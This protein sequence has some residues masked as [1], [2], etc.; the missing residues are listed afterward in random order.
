[1]NLICFIDSDE[2]ANEEKI[3]CA[4]LYIIYIDEL[5]KYYTSSGCA[6]NKVRAQILIYIIRHKG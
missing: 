2:S 4:D 3:A 5:K 6:K 1:M